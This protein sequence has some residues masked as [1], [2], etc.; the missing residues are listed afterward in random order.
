[1][2]WVIQKMKSEYGYEKFID[3]I[4]RMGVEHQLVK[5]VPF[6]NVLLPVT[7]N[8]FAD[9]VKDAKHIEIE[10]DKDIY[11]NGTFTLLK[12]AQ[13]R[14]W[15]GVFI[16]DNFDYNVWSKSFGLEHMLNSDVKVGMVKDMLSVCADD[17]DEVFVRP[18]LDT[19]SLTGTVMSIDK[20]KAWQYAIED[21]VPTNYSPLHRE[22][23]I[24]VAPVKKIYKEF[25]MFI[26]D[27]EYITGTQYKCGLDVR[28]SPIVDDGVIEYVKNMIQ[29]WTPA[30]AFVLDIASTPYGYKV[31]EINN[32]NTAGFYDAN[33]GKL[34]EAI[35]VM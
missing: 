21:V 20:F 3:T 15:A 1:M 17:W 12:I 14:K 10:T 29:I 8:S 16:N 9:S 6:S 4:I 11:V 18:V 35:E 23:E 31:I 7:F 13:E 27:G 2:F 5:V 34:I 33:V 26:V 30:K 32:I 22:T 24:L 25:R 19:K 28:Y